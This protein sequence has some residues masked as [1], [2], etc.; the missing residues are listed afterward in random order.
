MKRIPNNNH[1]LWFDGI[2][3]WVGKPPLLAGPFTNS[4]LHDIAQQANL[5]AEDSSIVSL[6]K[7]TLYSVKSKS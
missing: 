2:H 5:T 7:T 3:Y 1:S 6:D 4:E